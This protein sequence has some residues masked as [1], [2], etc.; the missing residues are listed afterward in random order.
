MFES[1]IIAVKK[2]N[3]YKNKNGLE[4]RYDTLTFILPDGESFR[5]SMNGL[6]NPLQDIRPGDI[7]VFG[8]REKVFENGGTVCALY[9]QSVRPA[10]G[11]GK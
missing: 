7:A 9:I 5:L 1:K 4:V 10:G 8:V 3:S 2:G 6:A 11:A